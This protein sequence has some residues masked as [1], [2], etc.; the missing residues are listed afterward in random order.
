MKISKIA[1]ATL[2]DVHLGHPRTKTSHITENLQKYLINDPQFEDLDLITINGDWWDQLLTMTSD[3]ATDAEEFIFHLLYRCGL[4]NIK[5]RVLEGTPLHDC[6]HSA[7]FEQINKMGNLGCDIKYFDTLSIEHITDLDIHILYLPDE[8]TTDPDETWR[9]VCELLKAHGLEQVDYVV[10]HGAFIY[11]LPP[12][13][14]HNCHDPRRWQS[15]VKKHILINHI[16]TGSQ[17]EKILAPGSFD[18]LKHSEEEPKGYLR[19]EDFGTHTEIKFIENAGAK[20]YK[21]FNVVN[22]SIEEVYAMLEIVNTYPND[23]FIRIQASLNDPIV[24]GYSALKAMYPQHQWSFKKVSDE[25]P[26]DGVV[27]LLPKRYVAKPINRG[28]FMDVLK[29]KLNRM[30]VDQNDPSY[31]WMLNYSEGVVNETR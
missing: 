9:L 13:A 24:H 4:A 22:K 25:S 16:H 7:K 21:T 3:A 1:I 31:H 18:R 17:Y 14:Q 20:I 19:I 26:S 28:N 10:M 29:D 15:I 23:S 5:V 2:G 6:K 30:G 27:A 12:Q 11:Q 8:F